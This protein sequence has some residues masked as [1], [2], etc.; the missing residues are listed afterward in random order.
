MSLP[1]IIAIAFLVG[2]L[3]G[4]ATAWRVQGWRFDAERAEQAQ[5]MHRL[6]NRQQAVTAK[7]DTKHAQVVERI[8]TVTVTQIKEVPTYVSDSDCPLSPGFRVLHDAAVAGEL[9]D[10]SRI[11]DAAPVPAPDVAETA[12]EN[13]GICRETAQRLTDLQEWVK[14]QKAAAP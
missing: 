12:V 13:A 14:Q 4:G 7:V 8:R 1:S 9:P 5:E 11:A 2:S 10:P 6:A 3:L